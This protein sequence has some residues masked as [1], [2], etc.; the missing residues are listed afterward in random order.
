MVFVGGHF[1]EWIQG[2]RGPDG[3]VALVTLYCRSAG[4]RA[5]VRPSDELEITQSRPVLDSDKVHRFFSLLGLETRGQ[6]TLD[7][8]FPPGGGAGMSTAALVAI[9]REAGAN[10]TEIAG[11]CFAIE[12]A[13][14]PLMLEAPDEVL[15]ASRQAQALFA[16][17]PPPRVEVIGGFWGSDVRTDP[18]DQDFPE[19]EDL[20]GK[21]TEG[22]DAALAAQIA[23]ESA[24]RTT[25]VRG[26]RDDPTKELALALGALGM[27]RAHTGSA[28]GLIY[29]PGTA[30]K[31]A[32]D[33]LKRQGYRDVF[34]FETG[35]R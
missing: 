15:W 18:D 33:V 5:S 13:T 32:A 10:D 27:A 30:P 31:D 17:P 20:I 6:I 26:P 1:G 23:T 12:G 19:V 2:R 11:A 21:W 14:D 35:S 7:L 4:A 22:P 9:A 24:E 25:A 8:D 16:V 34:R 3:P 28:R 29:T